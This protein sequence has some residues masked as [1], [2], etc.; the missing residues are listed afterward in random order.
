MYK[1][2]N[3]TFQWSRGERS[4]YFVDTTLFS[5]P[6]LHRQNSCHAISIHNVCPLCSKRFCLF[7][8][9]EEISYTAT[10]VNPT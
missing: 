10:V 6:C 3:G 9:L 7:I 8:F 1:G 2:R 4:S 5:N